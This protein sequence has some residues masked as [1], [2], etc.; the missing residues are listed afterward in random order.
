MAKQ[1]VLDC[2]R[3]LAKTSRLEVMPRDVQR[4][5]ERLAQT[6]SLLK[7]RVEFLDAELLRR[8]QHITNYVTNFVGVPSGA[9]RF[10][11]INP[12]DSTRRTADIVGTQ[13][14]GTERA[15]GVAS[16]RRKACAGE[17]IFRKEGLP[18]AGTANAR[19]GCHGSGHNTQRSYGPPG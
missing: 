6:N 9:T 5:L 2:T 12:T 17:A 15:N 18:A 1:K 4:D 10:L 3:E 8:P 11:K 7:A 13:P 14:S 16:R 19:T